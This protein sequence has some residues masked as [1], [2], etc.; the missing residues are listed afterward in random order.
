MP[1]SA[2]PLH[3]FEPVVGVKEVIRVIRNA[4]EP[5]EVLRVSEISRISRVS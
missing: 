3:E 1:V 2:T 5:E 4:F